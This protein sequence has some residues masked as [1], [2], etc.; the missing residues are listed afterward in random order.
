MYWGWSSLALTP[1]IETVLISISKKFQKDEQNPQ[2]QKARNRAR[3]KLFWGKFLWHFE[4]EQWT[5]DCWPWN[6]HIVDSV[7]M[8]GNEPPNQQ[9][10]FDLLQN[11]QTDIAHDLNQYVLYPMTAFVTLSFAPLLVLSTAGVPTIEGSIEGRFRAGHG[12]LTWSFNGWNGVSPDFRCLRSGGS[13]PTHDAKKVGCL[14]SC[15]HPGSS[16]CRI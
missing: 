15:E 11:H 8:N 7:E 2:K 16:Q 12:G 1:K 10:L 3:T 6:A 9:P 13:E 4:H 14:G 5:A